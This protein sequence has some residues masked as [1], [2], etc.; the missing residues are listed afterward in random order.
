MTPIPSTFS[1]R[2]NSP[3]AISISSRQ[4]PVAVQT[5]S[6]NAGILA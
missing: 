3:S 5:I 4:R 1:K 2:T 6:R